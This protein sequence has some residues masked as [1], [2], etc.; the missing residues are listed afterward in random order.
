MPAEFTLFFSFF[1]GENIGK[2]GA[3]HE[4]GWLLPFVRRTESRKIV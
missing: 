2:Q 3:A 1:Q 4:Y